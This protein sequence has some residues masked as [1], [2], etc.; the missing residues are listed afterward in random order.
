MSRSLSE[1]LTD[2]IGVAEDVITRPGRYHG[3]RLDTRF[4]DLAAAI[5]NADARPA[6]GIRTT[7]AALV[8]VIA[9]EEFFASDREPTSHFLSLAGHTLPWLR[10]EAW[11]AMHNEKELVTERR[12]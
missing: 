3:Y 12:R 11:T 8:M 9:L 10:A 1:I 2:L 4:T 5:R 7:R 6:E